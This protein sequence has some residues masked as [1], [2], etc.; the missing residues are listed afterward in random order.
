VTEFLP[1]F[2]SNPSLPPPRPPDS[3]FAASRFSGDTY[4]ESADRVRLTG[5]IERIYTLMGDNRWRTLSEIEAA[6]GDPAASV[7]AQLR[8]LRKKS[9][10]SHTINKRSRGE[11]SHGLF[12]YQ[13]EGQ[14]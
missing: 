11:R 10:G 9:F 14:T 1:L 6:T 7:S 3:P 4:D 2:D 12:E 13:L 8:N 5:Q